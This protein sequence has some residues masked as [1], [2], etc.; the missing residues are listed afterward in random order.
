[1]HPKPVLVLDLK[2]ITSNLKKIYI[3]T[4]VII[5]TLSLHA[6]DEVNTVLELKV[7]LD[8]PTP[9]CSDFLVSCFEILIFY[10]VV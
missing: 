5:A 1:M 8:Q 3:P 6:D 9:T 2:Q 4:L 10:T 7:H